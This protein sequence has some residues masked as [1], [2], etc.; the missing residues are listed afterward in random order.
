MATRVFTDLGNSLGVESSGYEQGVHFLK[1]YGDKSLFELF[2]YLLQMTAPIVGSEHTLTPDTFP[3]FLA[4]MDT[5]DRAELVLS[6]LP[7]PDP[8]MLKWTLKEVAMFLPE[9][10]RLLLGFAPRLP[11]PPG[12]RKRVFP[13]PEA[14]RDAR[15]EVAN[16]MIDRGLSFADAKKKVANQRKVSLSSVQRLFKGELNVE[17]D[18]Q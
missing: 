16:L 3:A 11:Q 5:R 15:A 10:R 4:A 17:V 14:E 2:A 1:K 13:T 8:R 6:E 12:G 7:E 18:W 9:L